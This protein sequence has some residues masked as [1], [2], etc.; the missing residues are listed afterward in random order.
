MTELTAVERARN[1]M[2]MIREWPS[3]LAE[4]PAYWSARDIDERRD[5]ALNLDLRCSICDARAADK[6]L[7]T[8]VASTTIG[9]RWI[10]M[11]GECI[12][13]VRTANSKDCW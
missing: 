9:A 2:L 10:D 7:F 3:L 1:F 8:S 11:C 6:T 13:A 4:A 5:Q 12:V